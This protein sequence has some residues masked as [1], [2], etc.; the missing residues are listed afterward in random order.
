MS[1][2][3]L[4]RLGAQC[5]DLL[6]V[7][8]NSSPA[9]KRSRTQIATVFRAKQTILRLLGDPDLNVAQIASAMK[10]SSSYL[11]RVL[12]AEGLTPM[13]YAWSMRLE[14]AARLLA[15]MSKGRGRVKEIAF[16]CGF[17]SAAHFSRAFKTRYGMTPREFTEQAGNAIEAV[18]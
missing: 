2:D 17:T 11:T 15:N 16:Q 3:L 13:R 9:P 4:A 8:I 12:G 18:S 7:V 6:D 10:V 1:E 5:L 14:H